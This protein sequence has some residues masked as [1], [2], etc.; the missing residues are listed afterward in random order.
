MAEGIGFTTA[1]W[2][3]LTEARERGVWMHVN[4]VQQKA[5]GHFPFLSFST[6]SLY[7]QY[8]YRQ[9]EMNRN[10]ERDISQAG[11]D[12]EWAALAAAA[13]AVII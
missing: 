8:L 5:S 10:K 11:V 2:R 13:A 3:A 4:S 6:S 7:R 1:F 12:V 9:E